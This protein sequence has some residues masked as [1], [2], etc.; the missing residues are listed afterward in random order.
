MNLSRRIENLEGNHSVLGKT[1]Y[2]QMK[3]GDSEE[4]TM[5]KYC[6]ENRITMD[7]LNNMAGEIMFIVRQIVSPGDIPKP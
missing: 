6:S 4:Q 3:D 2:I 7:D 5:H 1:I